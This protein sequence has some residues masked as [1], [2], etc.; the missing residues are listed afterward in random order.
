MIARLK[1]S[2]KPYE[3]WD[4]HIDQACPGYVL[5]SISKGYLW[6][7][8]RMPS[9]V[10]D[11]NAGLEPK[12]TEP[13]AK[14]KNIAIYDLYSRGHW[15]VRCAFPQ[16]SAVWVTFLRDSREITLGSR[17]GFMVHVPVDFEPRCWDDVEET[18][19]WSRLGGVQIEDAD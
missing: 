17:H 19:F 3:G 9:D 18:S 2:E 5:L 4:I 16:R 6:R 15:Q 7:Y 13:K 11:D 14:R 1:P 8:W 12:P 10:G